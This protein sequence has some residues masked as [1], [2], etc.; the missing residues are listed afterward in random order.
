M[1]T[2]AKV[3]LPIPGF[4]T[5]VVEYNMLANEEEFDTFGRSLGEEGSEAVIVSVEN[6]NTE[7]YG[8]LF[9][10]KSPMGVRM[11]VCK[12]GAELAMKAFLAQMIS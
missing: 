11:W 4:E 9:S 3:T 2:T 8:E 12:S 5:V 7:K 10:R 6:W 1:E